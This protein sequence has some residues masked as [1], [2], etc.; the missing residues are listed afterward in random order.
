MTKIPLSVVRNRIVEGVDRFAFVQVAAPFLSAAAFRLLV[1]ECGCASL[2]GFRRLYRI[3]NKTVN[4]VKEA[5]V[6]DLAVAE[7]IR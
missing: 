2:E 1:T 4:V 5:S 3:S 6:F 7:K